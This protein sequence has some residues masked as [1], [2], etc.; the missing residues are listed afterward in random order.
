MGWLRHKGYLNVE[1][2]VEAFTNVLNQ[3][4][5]ELRRPTE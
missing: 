4:I 1:D 3:M 2:N 5:N